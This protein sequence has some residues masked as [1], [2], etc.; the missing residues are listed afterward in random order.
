MG[1]EAPAIFVGAFYL[2]AC[3]N[4]TFMEFRGDGAESAGKMKAYFRPPSLKRE[5]SSQ[6]LVRNQD[7]NQINERTRVPFFL[8][9]P[10]FFLCL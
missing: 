10:Q 2:L 8:I 9:F 4:S 6:E 7:E 1:A 5:V 3:G